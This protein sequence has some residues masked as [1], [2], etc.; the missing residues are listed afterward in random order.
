MMNSKLLIP[1]PQSPFT[2]IQIWKI[3]DECSPANMQSPRVH[4]SYHKRC[5][6]QA[7]M[8]LILSAHPNPTGLALA[9]YQ[10]SQPPP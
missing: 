9:A 4:Q 1:K 5:S 7:R 3:L 10:L 2:G 6:I 8:I